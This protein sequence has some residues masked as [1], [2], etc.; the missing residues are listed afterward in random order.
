M[1][2]CVDSGQIPFLHLLNLET[3]NYST[4]E[5]ILSGTSNIAKSGK[6]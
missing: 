1:Y 4:A 5:K 2:E 3:I 6:E